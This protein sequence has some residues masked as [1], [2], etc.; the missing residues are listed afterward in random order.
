M[1]NI[2]SIQILLHLC[3]ALN[4]TSHATLKKMQISTSPES[5]VLFWMT[6]KLL[7][8]KRTSELMKMVRQVWESLFFWVWRKNRSNAVKKNFAE[9]IGTIQSRSCLP[10]PQVYITLLRSCSKH[11]KRIQSIQGCWVCP[12]SR[13]LSRE[14]QITSKNVLLFAKKICNCDGILLNT[15]YVYISQDNSSL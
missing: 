2:I 3:R 11:E 8:V 4:K 15:H 10:Y 13:A 1:E 14:S 7:E 5:W 6:A 9:R 12:P